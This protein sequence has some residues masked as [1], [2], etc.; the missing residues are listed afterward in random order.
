MKQQRLIKGFLIGLLV[1]I[2]FLTGCGSDDSGQTDLEQGASEAKTGEREQATVD[3]NQAIALDLAKASASEKQ[4]LL[5]DAA[6]MMRL[7]SE[8]AEDAWLSVLRTLISSL[9][10]QTATPVLDNLLQASG[11][12]EGNIRQATALL[13]V[14][15]QDVERNT[16]LRLI[17]GDVTATYIEDLDQPANVEDIVRGYGY[18]PASFTVY[19]EPGTTIEMIVMTTAEGFR[20]QNTRMIFGL[21]SLSLKRWQTV[22]VHETNHARNPED[23]RDPVAYYKSEFRA[24]WVTEYRGFA[25]LDLQADLIKQHILRDYASI[26]EAYH[27][28]QAVKNAIDGHTRPD[29][30]LTNE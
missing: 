23:S 8:L 17:N 5:T 22:L 21:K 16:A 20:R 1:F 10:E 9:D 2:I 27:H 29:G 15:D 24:Y 14:S 19:Y 30:N 28:H 13:A 18:D 7:K 12:P 26:S 25:D 3:Y 4:A 11:L 6:I